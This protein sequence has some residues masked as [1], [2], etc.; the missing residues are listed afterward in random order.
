MVSSAF[1][2]AAHINNVPKNCIDVSSQTC[3]QFIERRLDEL[4]LLDL[5]STCPGQAAA[6]RRDH[7]R[8]QACWMVCHSTTCCLHCSAYIATCNCCSNVGGYHFLRTEMAYMEGSGGGCATRCTPSTF[9]F[10]P[11]FSSSL[12][13][14]TAIP[15]LICQAILGEQTPR[16]PAAAL[17]QLTWPPPKGPAVQQTHIAQACWMPGMQAAEDCKTAPAALCMRPSTQRA[18][19]ANRMKQHLVN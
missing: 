19:G 11:A 7:F 17:D 12:P 15:E 9:S 2:L 4:L 16:M 3:Q 8:C 13:S 1:S 6:A 5:L 18:E 10:C 14:S